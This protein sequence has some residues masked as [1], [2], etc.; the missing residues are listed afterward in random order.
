MSHTP[1]LSQP[2]EPLTT[3]PSLP[4]PTT[5]VEVP[6][7][8]QEMMQRVRAEL[9]AT[10]D[11]SRQARLLMEVAN[12]EERSGDEPAAARDYLAAYN[13]DQ[14]MREPLEGLVRLLDKRR[15]LKNLGKLVDALVRAAA[16]PDEKVR[17]LLMRAAYQAD[18]AGDLAEAKRNTEEAT[19]IEGSPAAERASAWLAREVLAGKTGDVEAREAALAERT[20]HALQ[21]EW[22]ALLLLDR[23]RMAAGSAHT[24]A[25]VALLEEARSL[26]SS[27]TWAATTALEQ[28]TGEE[29]S[30][31]QGDGGR[32]RVEAHANALDALAALLEQAVLDEARGEALGVPLWVRQP[33]RLI[34]AWLRAAE[35]WRQLGQFDRAGATLDRALEYLGKGDGETS[36]I[37]QG[38]VVAARIRIA[39]QT[40]NTELAAELAE[41]RLATEKDGGLAAALAMRIAEHA[42]SQGDAS[43]AFEALSRA[44]SNDPGCLPARALQLDMLADGGDPA[45]FAAQLESFAD[46]LATDEARGRAFLLAA[47][48]WAAHEKDVAGAKAA[49]SQAAMYGVPPA[50]T[51]RVARTLASIADDVGWYE[52]ATKRLVAA[53]GDEREAVSLYVE[54]LRLRHARGDAE[55]EAKTLREMAATPRGGWLARVLEAFLPA[56][57][58]PP[59]S[60][61]QANPTPAVLEDRAAA[62]VEELA[63]LEKDPEVARGLALVAAIRALDAGDASAARRQLRELAERD[64]SDA[65]VTSMLADL[66]RQAGDHASAARVAFA[67][68]AATADPDLA[69]ALELEAAFERWRA[70]D[71]R[72]AL[73]EFDGASARAPEAAKMILAWAARGVDVD[74]PDARRSAIE[75]ATAADTIDAGA[76]ALERFAVE[77][78]AADPDAALR[79]LGAIDRLPEGPIGVAGALARL[80][81]SPGAGDAAAARE[82][83]ARIAARGPG[84][85]SLAAAEQMRLARGWSDPQ[86]LARAASR[87]FDAAGGLPAALEW[88]AA[89]I[90]AGEP[91]EEAAARMAMAAELPGD[92]RE[93][94]VASAVL[95]R[96]LAEPD[97]PAPQVVGNSAAARLANLEVSP[98]GCDPR[99]RAAALTE[100]D[101][102]LGEDA[103]VDAIS[104]AGWSTLAAADVEGARAHFERATSVRPSDL[105]AWEGLRSCAEL[106]QDRGLRARAAAE[107]G[108]RCQDADRGAAFWEEAALLWIELGD[109]EN[110]DRA[111]EQSFARDAKRPVAFD[112]LFRRV[113]ARKDNDKL[114]GLISRRLEVAEEPQEI[115]KLFWEQA[116]VLREKGDQDGAL[117]SLE[118]VTMLDPDHVGALALLG[119]INIRRANFDDAATSLAR[120]AML[121][122]APAKNRVTAG[123]AAVDLYENKLDRYD[124]ALEV[125]LSLHQAKLST[126]PVRERL[127][128]AAARTGAWNEATAMLEELMGERADP[129]GRIEAARLAMTIHRDR[130]GRPQGAAAAVVKL[131]QE[132]P[133]DGEALDLLLQTEHARAVRERL[134]ENA[135]RAL[136]DSLQRTPTDISLVRRLEKVSR[137]ASDEPLHRAAL[138]VLVSLGAADARSEQMLIQL[139]T[140]KSRP[141]QIAIGGDMLKTLLAPG[142]DG[143]IANLFELLGPTLVEALGPTLQACGVGRRDKV[144]PRSG[145]ALRNEVAA[146]AGAFGVREFE[147]YIGGRDPLGVQGIPGEPPSLVLGSSV[148]A[149]IAPMVR[150]RIARELLTMLRGTTVIRLRD[151]ITVAAIVVAACKLAEVPVQHPPYAVLGEVER[152]LG[153]A[154]ARRTRKLLPELCRAIVAS[155]ADARAW[156]RRALA[157]QDRVAAVASGDP[158]VVLADVLGAAEGHLA[159]VVSGNDR[160][161]E[162]LRF[163]LSPQYLELRR[164][165]GLDGGDVA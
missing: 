84:A 63:A 30:S 49:L 17:A 90:A 137:A 16:A 93:A 77:I 85:L 115:Q 155:G 113:R 117:K 76:L 21:P 60:A 11:R 7:A 4:P 91:G 2:P 152:A 58:A 6:L 107:L 37:A 28:L 130:L 59:G 64:A 135:R 47:Y 151:D 15:S 102:A 159:Q 27:V 106:A 25:A 48:V 131:L 75:R 12:L 89:T 19:S 79:A 142:D 141:P 20:K 123:V 125:L 156:A 104:L 121:E 71:R 109:E 88:V 35:A 147:L 26:E 92:P 82:A 46:H 149:P 39:E 14:D 8:A 69:S 160:A 165:L 10:T 162:L 53:G 154:I 40:G 120:L 24:D 95:L 97:L 153:K 145:L 55:G 136:V 118:H 44:I 67:A 68:A 78:A 32:A 99:R 144:D 122:T 158:S 140:K 111:L 87:W 5:P 81:W 105:A 70:G 98:P 43:R 62:A 127:A 9:G 29:V 65:I 41:R 112:K 124:K 50:T 1:T 133:A 108:A 94:M 3:A 57:A 119:E 161:E 139:A 129:Q 34:D 33:A 86:E 61:P 134:L 110:I 83:I 126:L 148:N 100:L 80:A 22:R 56:G 96:S 72:A 54:L 13:A 103:G 101:G 116:R 52:E 132:S 128:R 114:L 163:V 146:W 150:G 66:D 164:S 51:A 31:D 36:Q 18:V 138:G 157:S 45:A 42:A 74:S 23:A 143:P 38:A 73:Q